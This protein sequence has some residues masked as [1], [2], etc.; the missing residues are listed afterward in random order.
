M[1][2]PMKKTETNADDRKMLRVCVG[3]RFQLFKYKEI[4]N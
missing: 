3:F 2:T 4:K 1:F